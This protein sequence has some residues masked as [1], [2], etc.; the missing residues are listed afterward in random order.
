MSTRSNT[1]GQ[2]ENALW[3]A[4]D[5]A[6][7]VGNDTILV[8][9]GLDQML[10][11]ET[12]RLEFLDRLYGMSKK[13]MTTKCVVFSHPLSKPF[14]KPTK[15]ISLQPKYMHD[16]L[17]RFVYRS[18]ASLHHFH[19]RKEEEK[20]NIVHRIVDGAN[21]S[22]V[23]AEYIVQLL[24]NEKTHTGFNQALN[25][26]PK[27]TFEATQKLVSQV[28]LTQPDTKLVLSWLLISER[29]LTLK[30]IQSLLETDVQGSKRILRTIDIKDQVHQSC[31]S[32]I[33]IRDGIIRFRNT[34][35]R[36]HL[37]DLSKNGKA[38]ISLQ[39]AHRDLTYRCL[40][41]ANSHLTKRTEC[42]LNVLDSGTIDHLFET[43]HLLE[44]TTRYW[45]SHF[46]S[47]SMHQ[48]S[49]KHDLTAEFR[50]YFTRSVFLVQIE[51]AC[52][53]SQFPPSEVLQMHQL[54]LNIRKTILG[55]T[56][57]AV[58]QSLIT[59]ARTYERVFRTMEASN[60]Y[61]QA[62]ILSQTIL[63]IYGIITTTCA[64]R[65]ITCTSSIT[66]TTRTEITNRREEMLKVVIKSH[67]HHHGHSSEEMIRYSKLLAQ[68]YTEI[69]EIVLATKIYREVYEA[70]VEHY[71]EFHSETTV[72]SRSLV[73]VLQKESRYEDILIYIR[74]LYEKAEE[75]M[76]VI[77][78]RR[79]QVTVSYKT[80]LLMAL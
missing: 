62:S 78:I 46:R 57:E 76:D 74:S 67:K 23:L 4:F 60:Y 42:K 45:I 59:I 80:P 69:E 6:L 3:R 14:S 31:G 35:I 24:K 11:G 37:I 17:E 15:S 33:E 73:I 47:S 40:A 2:I 36:Q 5:K 50:R 10:G 49:E 71:G 61:Y 7:D 41:Y 8:I 39:D 20:K 43:H 56:H 68:L 75:S 27:S 65:Y 16:D 53:E 55:E 70:C 28:D 1:P 77:D 51:D 52:W 32:L 22:F 9:D 79:I 13:H 64:E 66:T 21:G 26:A 29:P 58:L 38:L 44:Y 34:A 72:V 48:S 54:A 25:N 12:V 19:D 30:E 63:G 18:L